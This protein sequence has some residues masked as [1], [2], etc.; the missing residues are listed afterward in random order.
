MPLRFETRASDSSWIDTV[1]TS[2]SEQVTEMT[3]V[4]TAC[5]GL[6]LAA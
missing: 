6:V 1:W 4:A 5:W 2:T 3:S